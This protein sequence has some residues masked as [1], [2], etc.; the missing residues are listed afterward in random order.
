MLCTDCLYFR[1][2]AGN[3]HPECHWEPSEPE[4]L[5][6]CDESFDYDNERLCDLTGL[7]TTA[8]PDYWKCN[9]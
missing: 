8:C 4:D 5:A 2:D 3:E 1:K 7:C 9:E 6:P